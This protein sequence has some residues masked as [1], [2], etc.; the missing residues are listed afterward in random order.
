MKNASFDLFFR[1]LQDVQGGRF[2]SAW[3]SDSPSSNSLNTFPQAKGFLI[4][5]SL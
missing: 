5:R 1:N 3:H 2:D 4:L